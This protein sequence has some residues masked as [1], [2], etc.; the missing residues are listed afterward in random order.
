M[1]DNQ[2]DLRFSGL[3]DYYG[4]L[5]TEKQRDF[6]DLY[7]NEDFSLA[8]IAEHENITRQGVRDGIKHAEQRLL[9]FEEKLGLAE[10]SEVYYA[11]N[12]KVASLAE[13]IRMKS[14]NTRSAAA[15]NAAEIERLMNKYRDLF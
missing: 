2:K 1:A 8:E 6:M 9:E 7:Y 12:S 14:G 13:D 5:L 11:L 4:E 15:E 10:K 3:L